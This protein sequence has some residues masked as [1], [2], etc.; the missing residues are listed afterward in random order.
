MRIKKGTWV[1]VADGGKA[2]VL[3]NSGTPVEPNLSVVRRSE[4]ENPPTREQGRDRP[5]RM[6]DASSPHRSSM[7]APDLH[8]RAEEQFLRAQADEL[9][10]DLKHGRYER[11]VIVAPPIALGR[12]RD[13]LDAQLKKVVV[14]TLDKGLAHMSIKQIAQALHRQQA[15]AIA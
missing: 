2:V 7:E 1:F 11:L 4:M 9:S 15:P 12:L 10:Q 13:A 5:G 3:E 6:P 14:V 8:E